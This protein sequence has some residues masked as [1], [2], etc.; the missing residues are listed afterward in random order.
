MDRLRYKRR[1]VKEFAVLYVF[2]LAISLF[3]FTCMKVTDESAGVVSIWMAGIGSGLV[4][5]GLWRT[6]GSVQCLILCA[7][8]LLR[9]TCL[10]IDIYG[11]S[12]ITLL[13]SGGDSEAFAQNARELYRGLQPEYVS[14]RYPY[15]I[16][17]IY[18]VVGE[19]RLC[20]QYINVILW[21]LSAGIL[22]R[23]CNRYR[24][25]ESSK[26][27]IYAIWAFLPTGIILSSVLLRESAEMFFGLWSFEQ[28]LLWMDNGR[29]N[30]CIR[31]FICTVPAMMLHSASAAIW[32]AYIVVMMFWDTKKHRY[33]FRL[34]TCLVLVI[35]AVWLYMIWETPP[36]KL[37]FGHLGSGFSLS[38]ITQA[39]FIP[40]G[41]DYLIH[42]S[43]QSWVQFVPYTLVRMF[44]FLFSPLPME[45][46][47][48]KDIA[49]FALDGLPL[50]V[51]IGKVLTSTRRKKELRGFAYAAL[52]GG[53][54]FAGI[55]AWG[56]RNAG[57]AL[58][59]RYLAWSIFILALCVS[60]GQT[61]SRE[62]TE[63]EKICH[64][65]S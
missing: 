44:Y 6:A 64:I 56:V 37:L 19:N 7:G 10:I 22:I 16:N 26:N 13:H 49:M 31:A 53:F 39:R 9:C 62:E 61:G 4:L 15:I 60:C 63:D 12:Y 24:V 33:R 36:G 51:V 55:F 5:L 17:W 25:K 50:A 28:F 58:R 3:L 57:T 54:S 20:A 11:R 41:S 48:I 65:G 29:R 42:M 46:R 1:G 27:I 23:I 47:G 30:Y 59:H 14:T 32:A 18:H 40:G 35:S 43:C 8:Y 2:L 52:L 34:K 21:V 38:E 45:A